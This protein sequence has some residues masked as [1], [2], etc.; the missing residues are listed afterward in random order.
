[1]GDK[2][3]S[4]RTYWRI[5]CRRR[6]SQHIEITLGIAVNPSQVQLKAKGTEYAWK[7]DDKLLKPLFK[8]NLSK[9]SVG[10]FIQL[11]HEVGKSFYAVQPGSVQKESRVN[12][13]EGLQK[14]VREKL[15]LAS[16]LA[17]A[18][19]QLTTMKAAKKQ[20]EY[21][22]WV[23]N[24]M[25]KEAQIAALLQ[26]QDTQ[27]WISVAEYYQLSYIQCRSALERAKLVLEELK[28][29]VPLPSPGYPII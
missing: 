20:D 9:H 21:V 7:I 22:I 15:D 29:E 6:L 16:K 17:A 5:L 1:M 8:K 25:V 3:N 12:S 26:Q 11:Y 19:M 27:S 2:S 28:P 14:V 23:Q 13:D 18:E 10:A 4:N 24:S